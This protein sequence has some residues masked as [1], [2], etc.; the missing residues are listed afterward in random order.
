KGKKKK[1]A[2]T[3]ND[4]GDQQTSTLCLLVYFPIT[5]LH[6]EYSVCCIIVMLMDL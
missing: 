1:K 6:T 5:H 4:K 2:Y 3:M